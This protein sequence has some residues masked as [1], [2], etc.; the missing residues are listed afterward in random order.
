[1]TL[2]LVACASGG[3]VALAQAGPADPPASSASSNKSVAVVRDAGNDKAVA[4]EDIAEEADVVLANRKVA[5]LRGTFMGVNPERRARRARQAL[6]E[7]TAQ[8]GE[9]KVTVR[10][11]PQGHVLLIDG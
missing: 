4:E 1:M 2:L 5:T 9:G 6:R 8:D 7:L 11:E 10:V 3:S